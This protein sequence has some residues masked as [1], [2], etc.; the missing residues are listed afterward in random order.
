MPTLLVWLATSAFTRF[1]GGKRILRA[2]P[3]VAGVR[4]PIHRRTAG[5]LGCVAGA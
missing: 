2:K 4:M 3:M 1:A 5:G